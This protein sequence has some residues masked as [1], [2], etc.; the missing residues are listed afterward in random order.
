MNMT[1]Y[2]LLWDVYIV[3]LAFAGWQLCFFI[4]EHFRSTMFDSCV[5]SSN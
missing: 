5:D 4:L 2:E 1:W 3:L